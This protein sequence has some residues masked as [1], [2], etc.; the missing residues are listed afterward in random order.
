MSED[1]NELTGS[2]SLELPNEEFSKFSSVLNIVSKMCTDVTI[3]DGII[4]QPSDRRNSIMCIDISQI[5][6]ET[7]VLISGVASK[8]DLIDPF[9]RQGVDVKLEVCDNIYAFSDEYSKLEFTK[10]IESYLNNKFISEEELRTKLSC[11]GNGHI[12]EYQ[13]SKFLIERLTA[14]QRGLAASNIRLDFSDGQAELVVT[15]SD[16]TSTTATGKLITITDIEREISG[17]CV[18]PIQPFL[19][20]GDQ[21]DIECFFREDGD[22]ILLKLNTVIDDTSINIWCIAQLVKD[23]DAPF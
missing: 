1:L 6:G 13:I 5:V 10:P 18:F 16:N 8:V 2:V 15:A 7:T 19:L 21:V 14:L 12:F 17:V 9:R 22:N 4:C 3:R 23:E 20:G 11:D